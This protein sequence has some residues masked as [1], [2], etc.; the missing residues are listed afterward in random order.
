MKN[1][2][3]SELSRYSSEGQSQKSQKMVA[4]NDAVK[5]RLVMG[6]SIE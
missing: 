6:S 2:Q 5:R 1:Y 3:V 4:S